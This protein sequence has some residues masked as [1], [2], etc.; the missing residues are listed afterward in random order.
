MLRFLT[1][2]RCLPVL[3]SSVT[4]SVSPLPAEVLPSTAFLGQTKLSFMS[5]NALNVRYDEYEHEV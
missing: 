3:L 1:P 4:Q 2:V 5:I